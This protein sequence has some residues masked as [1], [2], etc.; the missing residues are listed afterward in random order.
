[1]NIQPIQSACL[2]TTLLACSAA[3]T[4]AGSL[5]IVPA[6][7]AAPGAG[8]AQTESDAEVRAYWTPERMATAKP[9]SQSPAVVRPDGLPAGTKALP[10][11]LGR[12]GYSIYSP[13]GLPT[14][15]EQTPMQLYGPKASNA[16]LPG[17][18]FSYGTN[19]YPYTTTRVFPQTSEPPNYPYRASGHL[20]FT[21]TKS[22]GIDKPGN[23]LCSASMIAKRILVT[24]GHCVGSPHVSGSGA[25]IFYTTWLFVPADMNG[26]APYGSWT[27][28]YVLAS[29]GWA[30]GNG[31]VP[32]DEDWG[33]LIINDQNGTSLGNK[34]GW[35][36]WATGALSGN[37]V[38][39]LGYPGNLDGGNYMQQNQA[40]IAASGGNNTYEIGSAM[41]PGSSGGPWVMSFG[42]APT[43][44]GNACPTG[45]NAMGNN[46]VV[47]VT[48][49]GPKGSVGYEGA[50]DLNSDFA[51]EE[52]SLCAKASGNC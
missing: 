35:F 34:V 5:S 31:S 4:L 49:Y 40:Q 19:N 2:R 24:A 48:S 36:G 30:G 11:R 26:T 32:N 39:V 44:T 3:V 46:T 12:Q 18:Q 7:A 33:F 45:G 13:P 37:N 27:W 28:S 50:S 43:C 25:F 51:S 14:E 21:I 16:A 1:M 47:A 20:F 15:P 9:M 29:A 17:R 42:D 6:S 8:L 23:Y 38:T 52:N 41:G 22:G 10:S